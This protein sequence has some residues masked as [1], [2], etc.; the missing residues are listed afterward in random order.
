MADLT[1]TKQA[2]SSLNRT[3]LHTIYHVRASGVV[4]PKR[5]VTQ[6]CKLVVTQLNLSTQFRLESVVLFKSSHMN[7]AYAIKSCHIN[8]LGTVIQYLALEYD[9]SAF[10]MYPAHD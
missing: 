1:S 10:R 6:T 8:V 9:I 4:H 3:S 7:H 5:A 2:V